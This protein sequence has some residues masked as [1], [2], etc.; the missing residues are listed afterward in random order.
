MHQ[1]LNQLAASSAAV[2]NSGN[3]KGGGGGDRGGGGGGFANGS[4]AKNNN[5]SN[6]VA[7]AAT[8]TI[9]ERI[10][11][12]ITRM[13]RTTNLLIWV[14]VI[15]CVCWLPLNIVNTV[16]RPSKFSVKVIK[17]VLHLS[18]SITKWILWRFEK[19][20]RHNSSKNCKFS[21]SIFAITR[22]VYSF[23]CW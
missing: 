1:K 7:S 22:Q 19:G 2:G 18:E 17:E 16:E 4:S 20:D 3:S 9:V 12:D 6:A 15:F 23:F 14:G 21:L 11:N 13:R 8:N 10:E 5:N